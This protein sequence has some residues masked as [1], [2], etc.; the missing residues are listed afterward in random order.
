MVLVWMENVK[1]INFIELQENFRLESDEQK[2]E[3]FSLRI[4]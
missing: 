2:N 4:M 1:D 3:T